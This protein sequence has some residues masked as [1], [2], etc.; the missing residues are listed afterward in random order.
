MT[1]LADAFVHTLH[2]AYLAEKT[3]AKALPTHIAVTTINKLGK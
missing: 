1:T 3:I 2:D